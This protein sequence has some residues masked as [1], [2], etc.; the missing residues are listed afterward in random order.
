MSPR[1]EVTPVLGV[2]PRPVIG[3]SCYVEEVDR[4][5]WRA[6]RSAVLPQMYVE[7]VQA[8]G[9][10][11]VVLPPREDVDPEMARAVLARLDGLMIAG[12][13]DVE[14]SRYAAQPHST[15]Q[16]PRR[17]RDA[18]EI[19][20]ADAADDLDLPTLGICRG[21]QVL[22]VAAGGA[23]EQHLPDRV[24]H[25]A[26]LPTPGTYAA[27]PVS[28]VPGTT[29]ASL[30]GEA[31]LDVPTYHHQGVD[32]GSLDHTAYLISAWHADGTPEA[33]EKPESRF[34]LA[35]Q[36]HPEAGPDGRL[37]DALVTAARERMDS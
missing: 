33:M 2:S 30:L 17:D 7:H 15:A 34:R 14:S 27:H 10:I 26:H 25:D 3:I 6:Q 18:W 24:G 16:A 36:W 35:V 19:A 4:I 13:A 31:D 12:G 29:L 9:G 23:I 8:A 11:A 22:A 5:P 37:F 28:V 1:S 20:L 21:M 32:A